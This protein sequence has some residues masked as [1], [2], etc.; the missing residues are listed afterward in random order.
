MTVCIGSVLPALAAVLPVD[1]DVPN[2][3]DK[4]VELE[5]LLW[6]EDE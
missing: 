2:S 5:L 4:S 3:A 6:S 1:D